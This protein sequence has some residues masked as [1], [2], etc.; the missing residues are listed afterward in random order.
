[1]KE[2]DRAMKIRGFK[3]YLNTGEI[4][5]RNGTVEVKIKEFNVRIIWPTGYEIIKLCPHEES[6]LAFIEEEM[7]LRSYRLRRTQ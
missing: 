2:L 6:I 5:F 3:K 1:M 4:I 7:P